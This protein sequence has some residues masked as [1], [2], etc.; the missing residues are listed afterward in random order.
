MSTDQMET[1]LKCFSKG[2]VPE[3]KFPGNWDLYSFL[4]VYYLVICLYITYTYIVIH[5]FPYLGYHVESSPFL[6][7]IDMVI[8]ILQMKRLRLSKVR[9]HL[10]GHTGEVGFELRSV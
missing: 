10:T 1:L 7:K 6:C 4:L 9:G 2:S 5:F 8:A 3:N